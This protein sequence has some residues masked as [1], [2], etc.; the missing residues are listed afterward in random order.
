MRVSSGRPRPA[1]F[2]VVELMLLHQ[3]IPLPRKGLH[4]N[5]AIFEVADLTFPEASPA[6][7][8]SERSP[9]DCTVPVSA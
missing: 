8:R 6:A 7:R 2:R 4:C 5:D 1:K 9:C 3:E